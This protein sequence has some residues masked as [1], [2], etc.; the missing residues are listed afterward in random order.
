MKYFQIAVIAAVLSCA[1]ALAD[2][3]SITVSGYA[4]LSSGGYQKMA[5]KV[6][7]SDLDLTSAQGSATLFDRINAAARAVCG[8]QTGLRVNAGRARD[9]AD[10]RAHAVAAAVKAVDV[11]ELTRVAAVR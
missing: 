9:Y 1:P 7:Y 4:P 6:A 10:C 5:A 3:A 2:G 11:P 8:E